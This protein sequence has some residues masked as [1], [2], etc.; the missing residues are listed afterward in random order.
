MPSCILARI[1]HALVLL[2]LVLVASTTTASEIPIIDAHSQVD[3]KVDLEKIIRLM[4][5]GGVSRTILSTRGKVKPNQL[6]SF[7]SRHPGRI[8]PSVR[9]KG[10]PYAR[11]DPKYYKLLRAQLAMPEFG[12][13][14][15]V[16]MWHA[17]KGK[18]APKWVVHPDQQQVQVALKAALQ[19]KWPFVVHIEF[20][21]AGDDREVFMSKLEG[22]L[23]GHP[24]HPFVLIHMGQLP[25]RDARR[26]IETHR[27]IYFFTSH[28]NPV[29]VEKSKQP[30]VNLFKG[31]KLASEWR[32]LIVQHPDRFILAFDN[33]FAEHWSSF[34]LDQIALWRKAFK[35]LPA[36]VANALAH[37]NAER[38]WRLPP[39]R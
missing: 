11:N 20:A 6:I 33:V 8:T 12:A 26:L 16:I 10:N 13:M 22:L 1:R 25:A 17:Q 28:S 31:E 23:T 19:R 38:L 7:A 35:D 15:E 36:E 27:N 21:A 3:H 18:R 30:W 34:Y 4:A 2:P 32:E 37:G 29:T 5:K 39:A 9:T 14:A 24:E